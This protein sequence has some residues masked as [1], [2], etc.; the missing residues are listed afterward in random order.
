LS[1]AKPPSWQYR[2]KDLP[3]LQRITHGL[4][5]GAL[6]QQFLANFQQIRVQLDQHGRRPLL[7]QQAQVV[8][9]DAGLPRRL[10][11]RIQLRNVRQHRSHARRIVI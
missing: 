2:V 9:G 10:L 4:A 11:H 5:G 7:P 6:R 3:V 1:I 8:T